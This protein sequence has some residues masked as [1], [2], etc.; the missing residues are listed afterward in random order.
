MKD[1]LDKYIDEREHREPGF[2]DLVAAAERRQAFVRALAA[3][4]RERGL[5]QTQIA[6]AMATSASIVSRLESGA[7][8]RIST[9][10]KYLSALGLELLL[11]AR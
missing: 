4:R 3:K 11:E 2:R 6:A 7:D 8:V 5:S 9:L 1:D 10:E